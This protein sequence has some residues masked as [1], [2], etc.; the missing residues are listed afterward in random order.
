VANVS[1]VVSR[2]FKKS[3]Q[4]KKISKIQMRI[5]KD[6]AQEKEHRPHYLVELGLEYFQMTQARPQ[7]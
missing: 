2:H 1:Q 6:Q 5:L 4:L 3:R 7:Q